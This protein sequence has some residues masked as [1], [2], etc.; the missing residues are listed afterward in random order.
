MSRGEIRHMFASGNTSLGFFNY[1]DYI[2]DW[3]NAKKIFILK[4]GPGTGKSFFIKDIGSKAVGLGYDIEYFHCSSDSDS[5]DGITIPKLKV[6]MLDGTYPHIMDPKYPGLI[7]EI[8]NMD[9]FLNKKGLEEN[10]KRII[11][12]K[13]ERTMYFNRAY[14]YLKT[15]GLIYENTEDFY[16]NAL[17]INKLKSI[18]N[19]L[20]KEIFLEKK[21]S[22]KEI[23]QRKLFASAITPKGVVN[24]LDSVLNVSRVYEIKIPSILDEDDN[25]GTNV[26][27]GVA[28]S[29]EE[30]M[31][32]IKNVAIERGYGVECFYC[33][34]FPEKIEHVV[35]PELDVAFITS[36]KYPSVSLHIQETVDM[37]WCYNQDKLSDYRGII[38]ENVKQINKL[39]DIAIHSINKAKEIH[40]ETEEHYSKNMNFKLLQEYKEKIKNI[41]EY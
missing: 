23:K 24:Y 15:V 10:K 31:T 7:D 26:I 8:I 13:R 32:K 11:E 22:Q 9:D 40:R 30:L 20:I 3:E 17:K 21:Y 36:G 27:K 14:S 35:I 41:I 6:S 37:S 19:R 2:T 1:F 5:L 28:S 29:T 12:K 39:L 18:E 4:G 38:K 33:A 34:L 25:E 16:N